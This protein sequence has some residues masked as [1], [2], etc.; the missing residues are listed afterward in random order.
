MAW[1]YAPGQSTRDRVR[2]LIGDVVQ[3]DPLLQ[4]EEL[5]DFLISFPNIYRAGAEACRAIAAEFARDVSF[6]FEGMSLQ[7][8]ARYRHFLELANVLEKQAAT[9]PAALPSSL[10]GGSP[11]DYSEDHEEPIF[12]IGMHDNKT[13]TIAGG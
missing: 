5:D 13:S 7:A 1:S 11:S 3:D 2:R 4:D 10:Q 12:E 8:Q 9:T 6:S